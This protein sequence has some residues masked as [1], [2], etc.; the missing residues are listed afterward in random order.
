[1]C[2][3]L[4]QLTRSAVPYSTVLRLRCFYLSA[5]HVSLVLAA[6]FNCAASRCEPSRLDMAKPSGSGR[7][8]EHKYSP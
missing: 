6:Q 2:W 8:Y 1:M 5:A 3:G 4:R 7:S